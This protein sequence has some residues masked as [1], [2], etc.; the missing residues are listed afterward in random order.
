MAFFNEKDWREM[1]RLRRAIVRAEQ[2]LSEIDR[3]ILPDG[4]CESDLA[5]LERLARKGARPV[6][7][8][9]RQ[10]GLTSGSMTSAVKRLHRRGLVV[11]VDLLDDLPGCHR[12][13]NGNV[14]QEKHEADFD[15]QVDVRADDQHLDVVRLVGG[16]H[17]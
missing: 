12:A 2:S 10:V 7:G 5:I 1:F 16:D 6:N 8:L 15:L 13:Q 4:L 9:A 11:V 14:V 17:D 3:E